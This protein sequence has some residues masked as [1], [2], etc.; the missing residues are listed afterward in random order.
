MNAPVA[1]FVYNRPI[2]AQQTLTSLMENTLS[3]DSVLYIFSDAARAGDEQAVQQVRSIIRSTQWCKEVN[4]VENTVNK[5]VDQNVVENVTKLIDEYG[6]IIV[7]EDDCYLSKYFLQ[8]MNDA[9]TLYENESRVM[10]VSGYCPPTEIALPPT[11]FIQS[12]NGWGWATW[13]R[14]WDYFEPDAKKLYNKIFESNLFYKFNY[15]GKLQDLQNQL[16]ACSKGEMNNWDIKWYAAQF[17]ND[18]LALSFYPSLVNNVGH[19]GSGE[20]CNDTRM[21]EVGIADAYAPLGK[22]PVLENTEIRHAIAD[23][24]EYQSMSSLAKI[25]RNWLKRLKP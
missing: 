21:F 5:G 11:F 10:H 24:Q 12:A 4:I 17:L 16:E 7:L 22:I 15:D 25:K 19:D 18:G 14:A 9:L 13:K 3:K 1:L 2:H 20:H 8:Y 23:Y 6:K